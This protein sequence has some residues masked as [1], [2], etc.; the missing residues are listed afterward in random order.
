MNEPTPPGFPLFVEAEYQEN[1][2][3]I[4]RS[5]GREIAFNLSRIGVGPRWAMLTDEEQKYINLNYKK[6]H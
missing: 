5:D 1:I 6:W 2:I 4:F 3:F